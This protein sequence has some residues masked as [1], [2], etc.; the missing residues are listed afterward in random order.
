[1]RLDRFFRDMVLKVCQSVKVSRRPYNGQI[2]LTL[3]NL[4][5]EIINHLDTFEIPIPTLSRSSPS[6][7]GRVL[8]PNLGEVV[9]QVLLYIKGWLRHC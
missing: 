1:M 3:S 4:G 5:V 7:T 6:S 2:R 9:R 8:F